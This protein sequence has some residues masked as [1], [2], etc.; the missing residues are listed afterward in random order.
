MIFYKGKV[1]S[2][3]RDLEQVKP[4][5]DRRYLEILGR[6]NVERLEEVANR[7]LVE[8]SFY[9]N[10]QEMNSV[11]GH[12][13]SDNIPNRLALAMSSGIQIGK[14]GK[15]ETKKIVTAPM[16]YVSE[17][18]FRNSG[19]FPTG[20]ILASYVHE[21]NHFIAYAL[22]RVPIN[23]LEAALCDAIGA[24]QLKEPQDFIGHLMKCKGQEELVKSVAFGMYSRTIHDSMEK[25]NRILDK[26][27]LEELGISVDLS[28]WRGKKKQYQAFPIREMTVVV[29]SS[30]DPFPNLTDRQVVSNTLEWEQYFSSI[31]TVPMIKNLVESLKGIKVSKISLPQFRAMVGEKFSGDKK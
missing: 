9:D 30:G 5:L 14:D 1:E 21:W 31:T 2:L 16:I 27:V 26:L 18:G 17:N 11:I 12:N 20:R 7:I 29:P 19:Y 28:D 3:R 24:R 23:F 13:C 4:A 22:Q 10:V 8:E 6:K 15:V 25:S